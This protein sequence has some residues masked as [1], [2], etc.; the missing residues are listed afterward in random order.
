MGGGAVA[1]GPRGVSNWQRLRRNRLSMVGLALVALMVVVA[2]F[3]PLLLQ[4][5]FDKVD[6]SQKLKPPSQEHPMGT[7]QFGRDIM[8]RLVYGARVSLVVGVCA[9]LVAVV[10]GTLLG[11][12]AAYWGGWVDDVLMRALDIWMSFPFLVLAI[13]LLAFLGAHIGNVIFA[14]GLVRTPQFARI[15]RAGVL[16]VRG[17]A[18]VEAAR[19]VGMSDLR[20]LFRHILPNIMAT[21]MV[22]ASLSVATAINAEAALSFLGFGVQ[23]PNPSWG[24]MLSDGRNYMLDAPW[25]TIFPGLAVSLSILGYNLLGDGLR[26]IWDP[27]LREH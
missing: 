16:A 7:D 24:N 8:S 6:L 2:A 27:R 25:I 18:Y 20:I 14:I 11:A 9:T 26:D 5:P 15:A 12:Q 19:A 1:D 13:A 17:E 23:P 3:G 10:L 21:V 4:E 22:L